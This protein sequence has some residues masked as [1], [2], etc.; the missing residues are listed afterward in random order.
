MC[1]CVCVCVC[2]Q[3]VLNA[4]TYRNMMFSLCSPRLGPLIK[5]L[6]L[7]GVLFFIAAS[8]DGCV[9][10]FYYVSCHVVGTLPIT[11]YSV[12]CVRVNEK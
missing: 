9:R 2:V 12:Q 1:V 10:A 6:V 11:H 5:Y 4:Y 7:F 3:E 8:A